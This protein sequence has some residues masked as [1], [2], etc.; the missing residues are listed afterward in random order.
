MVKEATKFSG[1]P[2]YMIFAD[3]SF[4]DCDHGRST[5]CDLQVFQ[6]GLIDH[7]SWVPNPIALST[8]EAESNAYR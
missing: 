4:A 7:L 6:G 3:S 1:D 5:A 2:M 8:A